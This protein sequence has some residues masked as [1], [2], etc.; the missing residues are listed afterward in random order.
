MQHKLTTL[1]NSRRLTRSD[2]IFSG[3]KA[4]HEL[5]EAFPSLLDK[6][7]NRKSFEQFLN[8]VRK[9]DATYNE[10]YLRAEYN[11][12][13]QSANMAA[14]W[15]DFQKD[16]DRYLLQYRTAGDDR[17]RPA[18]AAL[19]G[20]TLP[21]S[22]TFWSEYY[23]PNG[24][25]C[26]CSVVQVLRS[27]HEETDHEA[28]MSLGEEALQ[29]D[30]KGVFRFNSGKEGKTV[31][32]YNPY[33]IKRC[34]DCDVAKG[35][36][37]LAFVPENEL[38]EAC[39]LIRKC[40]ERRGCKVDEVYGDRLLISKHA[41]ATELSP[42]LRAARSLVA[43]FPEMRMQI[44]ENVVEFKVKN[45]EYLIG[46]LIADRK[47]IESYKGVSSGFNKAIK[48]GCQAV[49]LDLDMHPE[50][51]AFLP[52]KKLASAIKNRYIDFNNGTIQECY[53]VYNGKAVKITSD[54]FSSDGATTRRL[55]EQELEKIK[56]GRSHP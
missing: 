4:F 20:V 47:G 3:I 26:R 39:R 6:N 23:P 1:P 35:D 43:S 36:M 41:D 15:E 45:P 37:K 34:R 21:P 49:V 9:I 51:F 19:E 18:H 52:S 24:W 11:F 40:L 30:K 27:R 12:V 2:Y 16:G 31:P 33:T 8:D 7:G 56:G 54:F 50:K 5:N 28:A 55:I 10:H 53:V 22:D 25:G 42:N 48:Q 13:Q 29:E 32:D 14:K 17:V 44:R 38:C 46:E